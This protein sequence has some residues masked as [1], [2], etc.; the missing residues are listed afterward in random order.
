M[1]LVAPRGHLGFCDHPH[2]LP[3]LSPGGRGGDGVSRWDACLLACNREDYA[4]MCGLHCAE[5]VFCDG[6]DGSG[7]AYCE[8]GAA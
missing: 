4:A 5:L 3:L 7:C 1:R 6:C 2:Y 8:G